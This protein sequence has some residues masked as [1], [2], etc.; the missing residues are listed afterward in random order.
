MVRGKHGKHGTIVVCMT[1][2]MSAAFVGSA[3][4]APAL[5][6]DV[7]LKGG[8]ATWELNNSYD[9]GS[10]GPCYAKEGFQAS[11]GAIG[12]DDDA[13]D[14]GLLLLVN[15]KTFNDPDDNG[16]LTMSGKQI[17]VGPMKMS[18]LIVTRTERALTSSPTLRSLVAFKNPTSKTIKATILWDSATGADGDDRVRAS[19][20]GDLAF[21]AKDGWV[22]SSDNGNDPYDAVV[23]F[24]MFGPGKSAVRTDKVLNAPGGEPTG[25]KA[26]A[27]SCVT[28]RFK[29]TVPGKS[30]RYLLFLTEVHGTNEAAVK[31][32]LRF[33][34][35]KP[36]AKAFDGLPKNVRKNV[37]NFDLA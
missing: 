35:I 33:S 8:G 15:G 24:V 26:D 18:K 11:D 1:V 27:E 30:T 31:Q 29:I 28:T 19:A 25:P 32:A 17:D 13:F 7:D 16:N 3:F 34:S 23:T 9:Y 20:N 14:G 36:D 12:T 5:I 37:L 22:V 21:T 10:G 6:E 2:A 4:G